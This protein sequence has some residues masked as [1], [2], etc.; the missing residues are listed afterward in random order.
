MEKMVLNAF[1]MFGISTMVQ[2]IGS[3]PLHLQQNGVYLPCV[4]GK[5]GIRP[6]QCFG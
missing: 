1:G 3:L 6:D 4:L 5:T 2:K